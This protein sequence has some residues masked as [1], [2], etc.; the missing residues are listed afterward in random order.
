[1]S[2]SRHGREVAMR[3]LG[4]MLVVFGLVAVTAAPVAAAKPGP[5]AN[6]EITG[7]IAAKGV[8]R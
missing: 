8:G 1:M 6:D 3:R 4:I 7:A 2:A 5:P